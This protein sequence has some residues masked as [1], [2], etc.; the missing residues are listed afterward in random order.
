MPSESR[1]AI[2]IH[3]AESDSITYRYVHPS[4]HNTLISRGFSTVD[5]GEYGPATFIIAEGDEMRVAAQ[6]ELV[7]AALRASQ[8]PAEALAE[9]MQTHSPDEF[10]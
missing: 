6:L 1:V 10:F 3:L 5:F 7:A 4:V 2:T 8:V 9:A